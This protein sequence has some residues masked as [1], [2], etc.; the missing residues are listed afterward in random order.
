MGRSPVLG[1]KKT[2]SFIETFKL[3]VPAFQDPL[4]VARPISTEGTLRSFRVC[5]PASVVEAWANLL[6]SKAV[7]AWAV[8]KVV[9]L[10]SNRPGSALG[11]VGV[12]VEGVGVVDTGV[13]GLP[14]DDEADVDG[15]AVVGTDD[16]TD[17]D[18]AAGVTGL[19]EGWETTVRLSPTRMRVVPV[20]ASA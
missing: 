19:E 10:G 6:G 18:V 11:A 8:C 17:G 1:A 9:L 16:E 20:A 13:P 7:P 3:L 5:R 2:I 12:A 4:K 14:E 15:A